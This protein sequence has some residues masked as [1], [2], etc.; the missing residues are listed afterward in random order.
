MRQY[1]YPLNTLTQVFFMSNVYE[2]N[3]SKDQQKLAT[4]QH[5]QAVEAEM[6]EHETKLKALNAKRDELERSIYSSRELATLKIKR[7]AE[8][9]N[10]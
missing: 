7:E 3:Q 10:W 5:I 8:K 6:A 2:L 9:L 4:Q 1:G